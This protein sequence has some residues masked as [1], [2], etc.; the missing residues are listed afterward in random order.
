MFL[1]I[2]NDDV[3]YY[4]TKFLDTKDFIYFGLCSSLIY[5]SK[6]IHKERDIRKKYT[7]KK[8]KYIFNKNSRTQIKNIEYFIIVDEIIYLSKYIQTQDNLGLTKF[9]FK[10]VHDYLILNITDDSINIEYSNYETTMYKIRG[11]LCLNGKVLCFS[12][13]PD[14]FKKKIREHKDL[15]TLIY[16]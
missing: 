9:N 1:Q 8:L 6:Y 5:N 16:T 13:N 4:T 15:K 7:P 2:L 11:I 12:Q 3:I 14:V 10:K